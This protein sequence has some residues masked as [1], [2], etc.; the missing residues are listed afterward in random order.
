MVRYGIVGFGLHAV[1]RLMPAF[2]KSEQSV[3]V[4]LSRRDQTKARENA[5]HYGIPNVFATTEELCRCPDVDAVFVTTPNSLHLSDV[6]TSARHGKHILCEKPMAMNIEQAEQMIAAADSAGVQLGIAQCFRFAESV[7]RFRERVLRGDLGTVV[8][9]RCDF[10]FLG[11]ESSRAWLRNAAISG[12]GPINDI[13]VH[14]I[15]ALRYILGDDPIRV[16]ALAEQDENFSEVEASAAISLLFP[17][18]ALGTVTVSYRSPYRTLLEV[19]GTEGV[20]TARNGLTI[21]HPVTIDFIPNEGAAENEVVD[22]ARA[23]V[24]QVDAF[25]A[26]VEGRQ[27]F[28]VPGQEGAIN[29]R[30]LDAAYRSA[31]SGHA[32]DLA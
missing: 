27:Q 9:A 4:A 20:L 24:L 6:L 11:T 19:V 14:C 10:S 13:G 29:Q 32:E 26:A 17:K 8:A 28:P 1:R 23:Y 30:I 12:G 7:N 21:N 25:S 2:Q 16:S 22:N 31:K 18:G 15:D 3:A 5:E